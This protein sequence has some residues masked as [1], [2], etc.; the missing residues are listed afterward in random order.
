M[1]IIQF[2]GRT[3]SGAQSLVILDSAAKSAPGLR[4]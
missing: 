3:K 1:L 2:L 4:L